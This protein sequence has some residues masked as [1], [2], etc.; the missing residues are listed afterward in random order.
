MAAPPGSWSP[1]R[2]ARDAQRAVDRLDAMA[3]AGQPTAVL[4][5]AAPGP[6]T[7]VASTAA[8]RPRS[9]STGGAIPRA[10]SRSSPIAA[11]ASSRARAPQL[12]GLHIQGTA[13]RARELVD[14]LTQLTLPR[15]QTHGRPARL[16]RRPV[17][18]RASRPSDRPWRRALRQTPRHD[19]ARVRA[20]EV[21]PRDG[22]LPTP[23]QI[24]RPVTAR[25]RALRRP[26]ARSERARRRPDFPER[27]SLAGYATASAQSAGSAQCVSGA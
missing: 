10:G 24:G 5:R 17:R 7:P 26:T 4:V 1:A 11:P 8:C 12:G 19:R 22:S 20:H 13:P 27:K 18:L 15:R 3:Q 23:R 25:E 16:G 14:A 2:R 6:L 9:V 21:Q